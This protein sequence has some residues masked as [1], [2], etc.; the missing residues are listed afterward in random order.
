MDSGNMTFARRVAAII[1]KGFNTEVL[2]PLFLPGFELEK[3]EHTDVQ[4]IAAS[5]FVL[6]VASD[7]DFIINTTRQIRSY[8]ET[9][10]SPLMVATSQY[11][12]DIP[13][14]LVDIFLPV[15]LTNSDFKQGLDQLLPLR[16]RVSRFTV[17]Q[18]D[19]EHREQS[20]LSLLRF[21]SSRRNLK[22]T[23]QWDMY[24]QYGYVY[25]LAAT[26]LGVP[27]GQEVSQ[28]ELLVQTGLLEDN[29]Y[30][31]IHLCP[32]CLHFHLNFR[33]V[34]PDC[35]TS[36]ISLEENLHHYPC[37]FTAPRNE[38]Q[39]SGSLVCPKC[40]RKLGH[41]GVDYDKPSYGHHCSACRKS[42]VELNVDCLCLSCGANF[43]ADKAQLQT[44]WE[45][46]IS[47][48]GRQAAQNG[49]VSR[50]KLKEF[51]NQQLGVLDYELFKK[52]VEIELTLSRRNRRSLCLIKLALDNCP[53]GR[54]EDAC[55]YRLWNKIIG[56]IKDNL[57]INDLITWLGGE[58]ML[59]LSIDTTPKQANKAISRIRK[60]IG[61]NWPEIKVKADCF[62]LT[63]EQDWESDINKS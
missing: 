4:A 22:L 7:K 40:R 53:D 37:S 49:C 57:R 18:R 42:F 23:P 56:E 35:R 3:I 8:P 51:L 32:Q 2:S 15:P 45:Y 55:F 62:T 13:D 60:N 17:P 31:K 30:D 5:E 36:D 52:M 16:D 61:A 10:L 21:L 26:I 33:E 39:Q 58:E 48:F 27:A 1:P 24:S 28:L 46:R 29:F 59:V 47:D 54:A 34:C 38:F 25:P 63:P 14:Q 50:D 43:P 9:A 20:W 12:L 11:E 41:L 19:L 44:I 6:L